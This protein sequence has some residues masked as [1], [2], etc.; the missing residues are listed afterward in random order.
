[1]PLLQPRLR[2]RGRTGGDKVLLLSMPRYQY[3]I[4]QAAKDQV[5]VPV[6]SVTACDRSTT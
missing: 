3:H 1:M 2:I 4:P 6:T 5:E